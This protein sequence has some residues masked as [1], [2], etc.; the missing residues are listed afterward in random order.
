M[1]KLPERLRRA[2]G[3]KKVRRAAKATTVIA[4]AALGVLLG[5]FLLTY[6]F[7]TIRADYTYST[8]RTTFGEGASRHSVVA[9]YQNKSETLVSV[10]SSYKVVDGKDFLLEDYLR[11]DGET[12]KL[13]EDRTDELPTPQVTLEM[14]M[15]D[16]VY[17]ATALGSGISG[18]GEY[19][20][21]VTTDFRF[22]DTRRQE[23]VYLSVNG[24]GLKR[25][26]LQYTAGQ[27]P[28]KKQV[29]LAGE[30]ETEVVITP[31]S[32]DGQ[33]FVVE[34]AQP[35]QE[36]W[37]D[38]YLTDLF[39]VSEDY[40]AAQP[41]A[42]RLC[43]SDGAMRWAYHLQDA[44]TGR[45]VTRLDYGG[46]SV[47]ARAEKPRETTLPNPEDGQTIQLDDR[48]LAVGPA[49]VR[50]QSVYREGPY[51][52]IKLQGESDWGPVTGLIAAEKTADDALY[53]KLQEGQILTAGERGLLSRGYIS[54]FDTMTY[55]VRAEP[56]EQLTLLIDTALVQRTCPGWI[57]IAAARSAEQ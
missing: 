36:G 6:N 26:A 48:E 52:Y 8:A 37:E 3:N 22:A 31:L 30:E 7:V 19:E 15:S 24:E 29:Q 14:H 20:Y 46:Y 40:A 13:L 44:E 41:T 28:V 17:T 54:D 56:G 47:A 27:E 39:A 33:D 11:Y 4:A 42:R 38:L 57:E 55:A 51:V 32:N 25:I 23:A 50:L 5:I 45:L 16:K 53:Q 1:L 2:A 34:Y 43:F 12:G 21:T 9:V 18:I 49:S 35:Q 10:E